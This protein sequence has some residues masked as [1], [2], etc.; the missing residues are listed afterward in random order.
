MNRI[1]NF[2]KPRAAVELTAIFLVSALLFVALIGLIG[3]T[4]TANSIDDYPDLYAGKTPFQIPMPEKTAYFT[5]DDGPSKNTELILDMLAE[6]NVKATFFV[7]AQYEDEALVRR[8]LAR[9]VAEGHTIGLHS[10]SHSFSSIYKNTDGYL[11][12]L[13]KLNTLILDAT[14]YRPQILRF[15]GGSKTVNAPKAVMKDII[16]EIEARGYSYYDW[17]VVSGDSTATTYPAE[18][19]AKTM[20]KGV[21]GDDPVVFLCHDNATPKTTSE[22]VR[23]VIK[24]LREDDWSFD[25]LTAEAKPVHIK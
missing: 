19:L 8:L 24:E 13:D 17:H 6:E 3:H 12:D 16:E 14:G 11:R 2:R 4:V 20:L 9:M 10:Y 15:P 23:L 5:F 21:K 7:T 18:T 25:R 22:A 1:G